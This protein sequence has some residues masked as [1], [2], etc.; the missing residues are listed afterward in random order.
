MTFRPSLVLAA[1]LGLGLA[2]QTPPATEA[3]AP[4]PAPAAPAAPAPVVKW[5]G[6]LWASGA[7]SDHQT[8]DGSLFLRSLDAGNGQLALDGLQLGADVALPDG[9]SL[10]FTLLAGQ[11]GKVLNASTLGGN[12][13]PLETGSVA[14][15]EAQLIWTGKDDTFKVGRMY[16]PMGMEVMD[17]TQNITASRGLLFTYA[18]PFAQVGVNWHHAFSASWSTDVWVYNGEDRVQ[19][20]NL[21]KTAGLGL[22]WNVGG[23]ADKF[24]TLMGFS[25]P[26]QSS[27]GS[28]VKAG[29]E[30]RK[31]NR[32]S[33][34]GQ[35]VWGPSTLVF[36][37]ESASETLPGGSKAN[38]SGG[39][40]I[41]KYQIS[42]PWALFLRAETLKD[43]TGLRLGGD[44]SVS[45]AYPAALNAN[46]QATSGALGLER[47][48]HATFTRLEARIDRLNKNVT[49]NAG[50]TFGNATSVTWSVG[51][52]F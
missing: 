11:D 35:W 28:G 30:G 13:Q 42:D 47:K 33:L 46:L 2:A 43:D 36:E 15:P 45:A 19:D 52:N 40:F 41:Y 6:A 38:W 17:D 23:A 44:T 49:D 25:G 10:K 22:T 1:T 37:G 5:R 16:T 31:R 39:G 50:K 9:F 29:A 14:W 20:N 21:G 7:T 27:L 32:L 3:P 8:A 34:A 12:G 4:A 51:T 18:I 24:V 26:E 48:W